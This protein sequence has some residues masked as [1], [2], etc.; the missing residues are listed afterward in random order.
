MNKTSK[1]L[2]YSVLTGLVAVFG[3]TVG[4]AGAST[5]TLPGAVHS[6]IMSSPNDVLDGPFAGA[7]FDIAG[8][9]NHPCYV[10]TGTETETCADM[11]ITESLKDF[12]ENGMVLSFAS[13]RGLLQG[14]TAIAQ[15][16]DT[17]VVTTTEYTPTPAAATEPTQKTVTMTLAPGVTTLNADVDTEADFAALRLARSNKLWNICIRRDASRRMASL[18]FQQNMHLLSRLDA[19]ITEDI[20]Q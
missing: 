5:S 17:T 8:L 2:Q 12:V 11:G 13:S 14:Q 1:H 10:I 9:M 4:F 3:L 18:C 20:V 7:K 16:P 19:E 15:A 6:F